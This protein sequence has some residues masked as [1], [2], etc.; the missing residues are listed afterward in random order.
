MLNDILD[1]LPSR[2]SGVENL[3]QKT[4]KVVVVVV[5]S[6]KRRSSSSTIRE[7]FQVGKFIKKK[8]D[9]VHVE[10]ADRFR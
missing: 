6:A 4:E 8:K 3:R 9:I 7:I 2:S 5:Q 10:M 1:W